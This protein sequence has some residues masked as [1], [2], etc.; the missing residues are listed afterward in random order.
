MPSLGLSQQ[1]I[2][3]VA[4]DRQARLYDIPNQPIVHL[5][6]AVGEDVPEGNNTAVVADAAC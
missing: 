2:N 4:Q 3:L 6:I 1:R 5:R